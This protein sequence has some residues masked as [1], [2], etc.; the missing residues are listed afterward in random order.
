MGFEGIEDWSLTWLGALVLLGHALNM[1]Y[2]TWER[3][4]VPSEA[5]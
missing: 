3:S 4:G 5:L 1:R 2:R